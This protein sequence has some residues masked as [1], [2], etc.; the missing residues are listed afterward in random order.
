MEIEEGLPN[1]PPSLNDCFVLKRLAPQQAKKLKLEEVLAAG[2][3]CKSLKTEA[4]KV[5]SVGPVVGPLNNIYT[6]LNG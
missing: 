1:F 6:E 2:E 4:A 5:G 3:N